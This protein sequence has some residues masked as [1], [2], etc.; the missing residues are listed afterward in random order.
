[1]K[2][3]FNRLEG[4]RFIRHEFDTIE[5]FKLWAEQ[6]I[7]RYKRTNC[8]IDEKNDQAFINYCK[9]LNELLEGMKE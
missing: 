9:E 8:V 3:K 2:Y 6:D 4:D 5:Q 1:M 7:H